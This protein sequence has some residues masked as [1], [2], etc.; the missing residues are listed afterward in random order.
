[1]FT[2]VAKTSGADRDELFRTF[3]MGIGFVAIVP[4]NQADDAVAAL[5]A[6]GREAGTIGSVV[7]GGGSA[8]LA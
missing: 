7:A 6:N 2:A 8:R 1:M 5:A 4:A 3:N